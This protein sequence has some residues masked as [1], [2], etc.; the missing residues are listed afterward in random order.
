MAGTEAVATTD[1]VEDETISSIWGTLKD[2]PNTEDLRIAET[3]EEKAKHGGRPMTSRTEILMWYLYEW[4]NSPMSNIL[5]A[6]IFPLFLASLATHYGCEHE[7]EHG[8]DYEYN[9]IGSDD[10]LVVYMGSISVGPASFTFL[11]V[12]I[13]G[14]MQ[15]I[16]Y[17]AIGALADYSG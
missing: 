7:A 17:I 15:A 13:S 9:L 6:L 2:Q 14:G 11:M 4:G 16:S 10:S 1:D 3:E 5:I 12:S 8:C